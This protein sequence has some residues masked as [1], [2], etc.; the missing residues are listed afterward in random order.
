MDRMVVERYKFVEDILNNNL[1]FY[2]FD[3][4]KRIDKDSLC[5]QMYWGIRKQYSQELL[6]IIEGGGDA[7]SRLQTITRLV[8]ENK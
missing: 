2:D 3:R 1:R 8:K 5:A 7:Y 4:T 6:Q